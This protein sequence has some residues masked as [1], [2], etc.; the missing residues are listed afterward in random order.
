LLVVVL[1][2]L[3]AFEVALEVA[4]SATLPAAGVED[5]LGRGCLNWKRQGE[6]LEVI[7]CI[8]QVFKIFIMICELTD[9]R[10]IYNRVEFLRRLETEI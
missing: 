3:G 4:T 10:V 2:V 8:F 1:G 5:I 9:I 6:N 7:G